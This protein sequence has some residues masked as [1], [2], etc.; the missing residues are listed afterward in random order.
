MI[1]S[2]LLLL[3]RHEITRHARS[4]GPAATALCPT[5]PLQQSERYDEQRVQRLRALQ[6]AA[7]T[8]LEEEGPLPLAGT[9]V[10]PPGAWA[11]AE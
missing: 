9:A 11:P 3:L 1:G 6:Q 10:F 2:Q 4:C 8:Q 7:A 5:A